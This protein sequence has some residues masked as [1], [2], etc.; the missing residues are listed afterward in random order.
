M[1]CL[2]SLMTCSKR[3]GMRMLLN[4]KETVCAVCKFDTFQQHIPDYNV[5]MDINI[6]MEA[7]AWALESEQTPN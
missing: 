4:L 5:M 2:Y 7:N 3:L 1:S 6:F